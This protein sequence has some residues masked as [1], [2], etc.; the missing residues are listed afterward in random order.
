MDEKRIS[1]RAIIVH[2]GKLVSMYRE[3]EGRV[4]Y[5]FPGGRIE[6]NET[7]V[8][9]VKREVFEEFGIVVKPIKKVYIYENQR[10]IE[11]FYLSE[12]VSGEFGTGNGEEFQ[13]NQTN[14]VYIPK[15][16]NI[17]EIPNLPLMPPEIASA[18]YNDYTN[19]NEE[20]REDVKYIYGEIKK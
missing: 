15:L 10:A 5:T 6:E 13:N 19:N 14:G 11:H 17:E 9:C 8:D 16:I 12:W 3:R 7:E 18:F 20:L 4:F 1:G 2:E